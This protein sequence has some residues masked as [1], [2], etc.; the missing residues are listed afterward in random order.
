MIFI[1]YFC[2]RCDHRPHG[3]DISVWFHFWKFQFNLMRL[4]FCLTLPLL[5]IMLKIDCLFFLF[6]F[7]NFS[8]HHRSHV[9]FVWNKVAPQ[10]AAGE[11]IHLDFFFGLLL[12]LNCFSLQ[13]Y[14]IFHFLNRLILPNFPF[15]FSFL[16]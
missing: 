15:I 14:L 16:L 8:S 10:P 7:K 4:Q 5:L 9:F 11:S 6:R 13:P 12:F 2:L 1:C 3:K